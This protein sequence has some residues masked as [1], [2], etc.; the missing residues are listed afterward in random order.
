MIQEA[1][2]FVRFAARQRDE[3]DLE[4]VMPGR[5]VEQEVLDLIDAP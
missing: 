3:A 4:D 1:L 5:E 2:H